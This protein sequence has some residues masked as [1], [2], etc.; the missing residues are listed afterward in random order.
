[1]S[2]AAMRELLDIDLSIQR[3]LQSAQYVVDYSNQCNLNVD[4]QTLLLW[5]Y[6]HP[7]KGASLEEPVQYCNESWVYSGETNPQHLLVSD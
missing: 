5:H 3:V 7:S 1:M 4:F 2:H 6:H